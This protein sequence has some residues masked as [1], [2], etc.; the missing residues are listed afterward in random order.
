MNT[1][2]NSCT[3]PKTLSSV[4]GC[5]YS[6][7]RLSA[8][9]SRRIDIF[10]RLS[11]QPDQDTDFII[12]DRTRK[13]YLTN[14]SVNQGTKMSLRREMVLVRLET[15]CTTTKQCEPTTAVDML[16]KALIQWICK[17]MSATLTAISTQDTEYVHTLS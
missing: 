15:T 8:K 7:W 11:F 14:V 4:Y 10:R 2:I 1:T 12:G 3:L 6:D 16:T 9:L 13:F 5:L 17:T